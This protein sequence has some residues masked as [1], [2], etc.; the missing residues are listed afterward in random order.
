MDTA[1]LFTGLSHIGLPTA[2][3][4]KTVKFYEQFGFR[5]RWSQHSSPESH[6]VFMECGSCVM[7]IYY[8][9]T[10]AGVNGAVDHVAID[11]SD[12]EAVYEYVTSLGYHSLEEAVTFLPF[13]EKGVRFF[14]ILGPNH[15][16]VEFSQRLC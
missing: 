1:N 13:Y 9:K 2:D 10:P 14:T 8:S 16:K 3:V 7:E 5:I 11:V 6:T 4:E 12:I 15:E